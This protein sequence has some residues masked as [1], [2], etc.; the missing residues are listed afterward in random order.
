[1]RRSTDRLGPSTGQPKV[2]R[3][4]PAMLVVVRGQP[5]ADG[6]RRKATVRERADE[7][8]SR[9]HDPCDVS[10]H[11]DRRSEVVDRDAAHRRVEGVV[12][13]R[14]SRVAVEVV[15]HRRRG[16]RV[17]SEL[18]GVHAEDGQTF[19]WRSE[20]RDPRS[21]QVENRTTHAELFV[22]RAHRC[23][24]ALVDVRDEARPRIELVVDRFVG[25]VEEP[26][27]ETRPRRS[28]PRCPGGLL[29][30][31][32]RLPRRHPR[33]ARPT[34]GRGHQRERRCA[35]DRLADDV[36]MA[37]VTGRFLNEME[38]DPAHGPRVDVVREPGHVL[39]HRERDR[40]GRRRR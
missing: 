34:L 1:M 5:A 27:Q 14:Q 38:Q 19:R 16:L 15:Q 24:R 20:V 3:D 26:R 35:V 8:A 31:R 37:G 36:R 33:R 6:L 25:A 32:R 7:R 9:S 12:L 29:G 40:R 2:R 23:D 4:D 17:G 10:E 13:E 22:Q 28:R 39:R 18:V 11:F 30:A 21:H